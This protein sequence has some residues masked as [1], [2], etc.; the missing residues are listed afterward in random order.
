MAMPLKKLTEAEKE[1]RKHQRSAGRKNAKVRK[2]I[3]LF[4][5]QVEPATPEGEYWHWRSNK[6]GR[7]GTGGMGAPGDQAAKGLDWLQLHAIERLAFVLLGP[8][9]AAKVADYVR[10]TYPMPDYGHHVWS[11]LLTGRKRLTLFMRFE[12]DPALKGRRRLVEQ[13]D[14]PPD[15][16]MAPL[17]PEAF[18]RLFPRRWPVPPPVDD[19]GLAAKLELAIG[20]RAV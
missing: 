15:G 6:A 12:D 10:S 11:E 5:D 8:V 14:W 1:Q 3:P 4:A 17:T 18:E 13:V 16:W 2:Q 9:D 19:G 7:P 20:R